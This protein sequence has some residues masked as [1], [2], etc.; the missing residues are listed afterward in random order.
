MA[1]TFDYEAVDSNGRSLS[2]KVDAI[3]ARDAQR[4]LESQGLTPITISHPKTNKFSITSILR[5]PPTPKDYVICLKQLSMLLTS[6][7][8]L[9]NGINTLKGQGLHS[10]LDAAFE[11]I[12]RRLRSGERFSS[13]L[14]AA[15]PELPPYVFQLSEAG[16]ATGQLGPSLASAATQM[17][18]DQ[19]IRQEIRNA[20]TYPSILIL[21]GIGAVL[22]IFIVVVP[23]FSAMLKS[24]KE[25]LPWISSAV[26]NTGMFL[27]ENRLLVLVLVLI[28]TISLWW[29]LK[30]QGFRIWV[31]EQIAKVPLVGK[32]LYEAEL[33]RWASMLSTMLSNGVDL[34]T[35][36]KLARDSITLRSLRD[37]L[38]QVEKLV[39]SGQ[40][41]SEAMRNQRA[42][43][44][45]A[46]SLIQ[47][48]QESGEL[49]SML[50]SL[51]A[52]YQESGQQ[53]MRRF[54]LLLEPIA[55]LMIGIVIG[56]I[57]TAIMLAITSVNQV[58]L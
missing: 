46:I 58:A 42:F 34:I 29:A 3:H 14:Q 28:C 30:Q 19:R 5:R 26:L 9:V 51:A 31:R 41:L 49:A 6:G 13:A 1:L 55:I 7:V 20:L 24:V 10:D 53:R 27:N 16:E 38:D 39:R 22:F 17:E 44:A 45:T 33:A 25:P 48:G 18:Y 40:S 54:L 8:P 52:L 35:S 4:H 50:E 15:V 43:T 57:V 2:G 21:T 37:R 23:R 36:L 47:V 12:E 11:E 32:W 56:G